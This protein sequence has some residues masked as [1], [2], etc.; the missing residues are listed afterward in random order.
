MLKDH[1][2]AFFF[3]Y[4]TEFIRYFSPLNQKNRFRQLMIVGLVLPVSLDSWSTYQTCHH[5]QIFPEM[6]YSS[7]FKKARAVCC[8]HG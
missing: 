6:E 8:M 3:Q 7:W 2:E 1:I 4:K 5:D